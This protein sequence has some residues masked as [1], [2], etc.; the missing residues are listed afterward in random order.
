MVQP[1]SPFDTPCHVKNV[2]PSMDAIVI[3]AMARYRPFRRTAM[4][5]A[6]METGTVVRAAAGIDSQNGH[7]HDCM[8]MPVITAPMPA[9][10]Y[11]ISEITP[12][13]PVTTVTDR[14]IMAYTRAYAPT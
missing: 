13:Y 2:S 1:L 9:K 3:V 7:P 12:A 6:T 8:T 4:A 11:G 10:E 14:P 5:P